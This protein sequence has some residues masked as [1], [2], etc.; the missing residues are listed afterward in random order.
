MAELPLFAL[1]ALLP[2]AGLLL[3]RRLASGLA[4]LVPALAALSAALIALTGAGG[5]AA[6][7]A[8]RGAGLALAAYLACVLAAALAWWLAGARAVPAS[9]QVHALYRAAATAF[10]TG[11]LPAAEAAARRLTRA[12]P[13]EA[14]SWRVLSLV[15]RAH[16]HG[17]LATAAGQRAIR[18]DNRTT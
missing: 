7:A 1:N 12:L 11:E 14:G 6:P 2:G 4:T 3:R 9:A 17:A 10:L 5:L 13:A 15:A 18:L 8:Q 16:G